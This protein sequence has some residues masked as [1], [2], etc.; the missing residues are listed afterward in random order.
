MV[1]NASSSP[2]L[3]IVEPNRA[4]LKVLAR[5]FSEADYRVI[6]CDQPDSALAELYRL[7]VDAIVA[8][9]RMAKVS[10]IDLIRMV[11]DDT[12]LRDTPMIMISGR[13]DASGAIDAFGAGADD[14]VAKP[15]DFSVL[16]ARVARRLLRAKAVRDLRADNATLDARV[17]TR[18]IELGEMRVAL[19]ASE[20]ARVRLE[21][22]MR[23]GG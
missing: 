3:L 9:L 10:G 2:R 21:T 22:L 17:V 18:A 15:F 12:M 4:V 20:D 6:A 11:R 13:S 5:R 23:R 8:E 16:L 19:K 1:S 14:V 7:P